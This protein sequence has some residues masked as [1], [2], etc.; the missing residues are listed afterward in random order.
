MYII[1]YA[2]HKFVN[3]NQPR[4]Q[5]FVVLHKT[6]RIDL[7]KLIHNSALRI[8]KPLETPTKNR[9]ESKNGAVFI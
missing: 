4:K 9:S 6:S 3:D 1:I 2:I 7:C 5:F 8:A